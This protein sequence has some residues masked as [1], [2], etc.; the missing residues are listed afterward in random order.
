[1]IEA[2]AIERNLRR[3]LYCYGHIQPA[4]EVLDLG[5]ITV[6]LSAVPYSV[7]NIA[8]LA[9]DLVDSP[10]G[11]M[12]CIEQAR[13]YFN[14]KGYPWSF[15][16][17]DGRLAGKLQRHRESI[18]ADAGLNWVAELPGMCAEEL[19]TA[20]VRLPALD[21][22]RVEDTATRS[23]FT[24]ITSESFRIPDHVARM[25]YG[26][27]RM[28]SGAFF[29]YVGYVEG[30]PVSTVGYVV[31]EDAIGVYSVGTFPQYRQ[32]GYAEALMRQTLAE[33]HRTT[34]IGNIVLQSTRQGASLY[35]HMGFRTVTRFAVYTSD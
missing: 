21:V 13:Q 2:A 12:G 22:R 29:G 30:Q 14:R 32:R 8:L 19:T 15:W 24:A 1:M 11:L 9:K 7:F 31:D 28:W 25:I 23:D 17:Y 18:F 4:A 6:I 16:S 3:M 33:L 27:D 35:R 20:P 34:G 10:D 26:D 5:D